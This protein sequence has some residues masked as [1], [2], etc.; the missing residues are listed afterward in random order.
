[1]EKLRFPHPLVLLIG[2][3]VVAAALTYLL[4]AGEFERREDPDTGRKVVVAGT[5]HRVEQQPVNPFEAVVAIPK[6]LVDAALVVFFVFLVGGAFAVVDKTGVL[7][8]AVE[9][10]VAHVGGRDWLVVVVVSLLFA[11]GGAFENMQEEII[12]LVPVLLLLARR[13]GWDPLTAAAMSVG[14]AAVA[15]SFSP[16]NPF[17]V[18]IAQHV[19]ELE[20]GSG[21]QFRLVF[22]ALALAVWILATLRHARRVRRALAEAEAAG[23]A[24]EAVAEPEPDSAVGGARAAAI[25]TIVAATFAVFVWSVTSLHWDFD[26]LATIF[27][28]MGVVAGLVGG[29]GVEGTA[30]AYVEGFRSMAFAGILIGFARAISVVLADGHVI[31]TIVNGLST[32]LQGL[33]AVVSGLGM[34][35]MHTVVH[36]PVPSVSGHAVLT[37]PIL[38]PL[39]DLLGITRQA[40]VLAYQYGAGLCEIVTPTNGALMAVLAAAGVRFEHWVRFVLPLFLILFALGFVAVAAAIATNLR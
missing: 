26:R 6:G 29:L 21:W 32:P 16:Y 7:R 20:Q 19:A 13:M 25:L 11:A 1:M 5:Y 18:L 27:F 2:C 38:V 10:L 4:P 33:P 39:S 17:Q 9:W 22:L 14:S 23:A 15:S 24:A 36:V 28:V 31:D 3:I 37:M 40:T 8:R 35:I 30:E 12:A 34:M